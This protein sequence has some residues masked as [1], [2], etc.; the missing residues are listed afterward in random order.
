M[1]HTFGKCRSIVNQTQRI[2]KNYQKCA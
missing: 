2:M 1:R